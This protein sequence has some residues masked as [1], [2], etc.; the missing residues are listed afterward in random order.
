MRNIVVLNDFQIYPANHGGKVRIYN[1]YKYLSKKFNVTYICFGE[2]KNIE[3]KQLGDNFVEIIVPKSLF[4]KNIEKIAGKFLGISVDDIIAMFLCT[5]NNQLKSTVKSSF[6]NC[7]IVISSLPYMF[8]VME[9]YIKDTFLVYESHNV[10]FLL[11]KSLLGD[12]ILN[13]FLCSYVKKIEGLLVSKSDIVFAITNEDRDNLQKIYN[14]SLGKI[15]ISPNG[16]DL[17]Q[18][19]K[20]YNENKLMKEKIIQKPIAIFLGSGHPP[21]VE[22]AENIVEKIAPQKNDVYFLICGSVCWGLNRSKIGKNVGLTFEVSDEEKLELYRVSDIAINPM[23]RGSGTNIKMLDYL[24]AGLPVI[25]T[26]VGARGL[27]LEN[28]TNAI[29]CDVSE[30]PMKIEQILQDEELYSKFSQSGRKIVEQSYDWKKI[31]ENM[32][33]EFE[34]KLTKYEQSSIKQ[35]NRKSH[36]IIENI[37]NFREDLVK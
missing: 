15:Y 35:K 9:K 30:F 37:L 24:A 11:K 20:L 29:I 14:E 25:S 16:A 12:N 26:P 21:N 7:D 36:E 4:Q 3:K 1:I 34:K 8:P 32:G 19:D 10:E 2:S 18:F 13:S 22:A 6:L 17:V 31:A 28:N 33:N 27:N 23:L 5:Y